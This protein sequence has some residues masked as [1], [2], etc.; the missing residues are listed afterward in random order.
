MGIGLNCANGSFSRLANLLITFSVFSRYRV[1]LNPQLTHKFPTW[2]VMLQSRKSK[3]LTVNLSSRGSY[4]LI[5]CNA[6]NL[7]SDSEPLLEEFCVESS[8]VDLCICN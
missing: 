8:L 2:Q 1:V 7:T 6:L 4:D 3:E 5:R